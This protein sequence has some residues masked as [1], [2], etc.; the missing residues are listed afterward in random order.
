MSP[1]ACA[2]DLALAPP[3]E[4]GNARGAPAVL[5]TRHQGVAQRRLAVAPDLAEAAVSEAG[6]DD[7]ARVSV[8]D[9]AS[10]S[11]ARRQLLKWRV[12]SVNEAM[13]SPAASS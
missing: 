12:C 13:S 7:A 2:L 9:S 11:F 6:D 4:L 5:C 1:V 10:A 3:L 8:S